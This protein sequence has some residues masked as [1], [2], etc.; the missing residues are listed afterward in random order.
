MHFKDRFGHLTTRPCVST[1]VLFNSEGLLKYLNRPQ[2]PETACFDVPLSA[3]A[4]VVS[5]FGS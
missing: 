2:V 4:L 1:M 5:F 3:L